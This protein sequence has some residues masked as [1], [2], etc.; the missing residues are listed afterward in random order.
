MSTPIRCRHYDDEL[1]DECPAGV[2]SCP[3]YCD[4]RARQQGDML[5]PALAVDLTL[6]A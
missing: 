5:P 1:P 4:W 6:L 3:G 2:T